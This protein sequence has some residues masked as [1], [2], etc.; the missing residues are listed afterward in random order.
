MTLN[1]TNLSRKEK[2]TVAAVIIGSAL[3]YA[4]GAKTVAAKIGN[5]LGHLLVDK[6][7]AD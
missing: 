5:R 3:V 1:S 6:V 4:I 2:L 7:T